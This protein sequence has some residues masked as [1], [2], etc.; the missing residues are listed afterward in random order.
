MSSQFLTLPCLLIT[1]A[2]AGCAQADGRQSS[3][4]SPHVTPVINLSEAAALE[5]GRLVWNN[6][7]GGSIDGLTAWNHGEDF[8]SMGIGH[9]IWYPEGKT[10]PFRES[11]PELLAFLEGQGIALPPMLAGRP[12]CPWPT[13]AAFMN[14]F[15][16]PPMNEIR[17]F[18]KY[19][20]GQQAN[21]LAMRLERSLPIMLQ[22]AAPE[23]R[24]LIQ[25]NFK[26]VAAS[27]Q[28]VYA[29]IDYVNFKGE[30]TDVR[31]R[32][33][34][35][36]WGL[37][38]VLEGMPDDKPALEAFAISARNTLARRV[39]NSPPAR[40]EQRW[41]PGWFNRIETYRAAL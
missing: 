27:P 17:D 18:L 30:G 22:A 1:L 19:T 11:F 32:Y 14:D 26:R 33:N 6:E 29:L 24:N 41:L 23:S 34:G 4:S 7:S 35:Q 3:A 21:F 12:A 28:G 36:G 40:H 13:R 25:A 9:F 39:K 38:Q 8:A 10:G 20:V 16:N 37:L 31:E 2:L 5:V 15:R